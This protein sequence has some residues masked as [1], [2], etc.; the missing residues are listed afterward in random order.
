VQIASSRASGHETN[1]DAARRSEKMGT[2]PPIE[3]GGSVGKTCNEIC[4]AKMSFL[5]SFVSCG[6]RN[7]YSVNGQH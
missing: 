2:K 7:Q 3:K 6:A 4:E 1:V 5:V